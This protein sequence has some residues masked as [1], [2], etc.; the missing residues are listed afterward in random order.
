M[1]FTT[2]GRD[3]AA[4]LQFAMVRLGWWVVLLLLTADASAG[5]M[6]SRALR[7]EFQRLHPC[8]STGRAAGACPGWQVDHREALVCG[9]RDE[10]ANLQWLQVLEHRAKTRVEVKLC[11]SMPAGRVRPGS[12]AESR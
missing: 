2:T 12:T 3:G 9:G 8:P 7:L 1:S 4:G 11:R 6:R 5:A 10:L